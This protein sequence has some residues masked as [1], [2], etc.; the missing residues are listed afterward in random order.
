[1]TV[2]RL[3]PWTRFGDFIACCR[4]QFRRPAMAA[5]AGQG[6]TW[7]P[8]AD[9]SETDAAYLIRAEVPAV[10][11]EDLTV[12]VDDGDGVACAPQRRCECEPLQFVR[13]LDEDSGPRPGP[14]LWVQLSRLEG[15]SRTSADGAWWEALCADRLRP[16]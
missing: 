7:S 14:R 6:A 5:E 13:M 8:A 3:E 1:M 2:I 12:T 11:K 4:P 9:V 10:A 16:S 15:H